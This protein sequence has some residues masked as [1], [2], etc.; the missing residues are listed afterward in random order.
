MDG[1]K[2]MDPRDIGK[3]KP[4]GHNDVF[5]TRKRRSKGNWSC[6]LRTRK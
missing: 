5:S 4:R 1:E 3:V 2:W 6:T